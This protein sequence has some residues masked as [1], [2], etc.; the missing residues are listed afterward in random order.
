MAS[1]TINVPITA[2]DNAIGLLGQ[3]ASAFGLTTGQSPASTTQNGAINADAPVSICSV[4]VGLVGD[5][6]SNCD[7]TGTS[8]PATQTGVVDAAVPGHRV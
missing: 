6:S 1:A 5:T 3:A 7:T 4:N 8:G 2:Q